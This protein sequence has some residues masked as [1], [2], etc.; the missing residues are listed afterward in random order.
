[1]DAA[2]CALRLGLPWC[3]QSSCPSRATDLLKLPE[4]K[5]LWV[6]GARRGGTLQARCLHS[7]MLPSSSNSTMPLASQSICCPS[8]ATFTNTEGGLDSESRTAALIS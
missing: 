6:R 3:R 5:F 1:M 4:I 2:A 8:S 7:T